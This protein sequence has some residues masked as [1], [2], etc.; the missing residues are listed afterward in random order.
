MTIDSI[1]A[2]EEIKRLKAR[3]FRL[4]DTKRWSELAELFT[5]DARFEGPTP[6][7][8]YESGPQAFVASVRALF[9][10]AISCH[11][12]YLPEIEILSEDTAHGIWAMHDDV[13]FP[14]PRIDGD[15]VGCT[16]YSGYGY[17]EETYRRCGGS[18]RISSRKLT[19]LRED[20]RFHVR[21]IP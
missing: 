10:G 5:P 11:Q 7:V 17:Y 1:L 6:T 2:I 4:L 16:G 15:W 20:R 19:R 8:N 13:E 14:T 12:G 9:D 21:D 18:W 3:Y